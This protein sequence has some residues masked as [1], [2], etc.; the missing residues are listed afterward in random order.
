MNACYL[1]NNGIGDNFYSIGALRYLLNFYNVVYFVCRDIY[2][3]KIKELFIDTNNII[4]IPF[5]GTKKLEVQS[6]K[7]IIDKYRKKNDIFVSGRHL[8]YNKSKITNIKFLNAIKN[9]PPSKYIIDYDTINNKNYD[10]ISKFY[11]VNGMNLNIFFNNFKL[12]ETKKSKEFY[13]LIKDY[14]IIFL[15][16]KSSNNNKLNIDS[17][18]TKNIHKEDT[19][20]ICNDENIY[21]NVKEQTDSFLKKREICKLFIKSNFLDYIDTIINSQEIY[22]ID[23]CFVGIILPLL[24]TNRLKAKIVRI[25]TRDKVNTIKL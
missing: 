21:D 6:C 2:L 18:I 17:L 8:K 15:Q 3:N 5:S 1:S 22:I 13:N 25:I 11:R 14:K 23:S 16:T 9:L 19:I 4:C 12:P 24:K 20:M 10:F 7:K